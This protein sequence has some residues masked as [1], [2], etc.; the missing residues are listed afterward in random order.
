MA[1]Y[2]LKRKRTHLIKTI[3]EGDLDTG[4]TRQKLRINCRGKNFASTVVNILKELN[5]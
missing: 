1:I 5:N 3:P 4:L 2:P